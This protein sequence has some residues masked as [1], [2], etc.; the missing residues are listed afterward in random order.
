[1]SKPDTIGVWVENANY[2]EASGDAGLRIV[3]PGVVLDTN[4]RSL[5]LAV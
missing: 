5:D 1:M 3:I 4:A 2:L